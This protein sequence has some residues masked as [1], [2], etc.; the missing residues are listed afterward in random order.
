MNQKGHLFRKRKA[1]AI[2]RV[3]TQSQCDSIEV[4]TQYVQAYCKKHP[5]LELIKAH[6]L[7]ESAYCLKP[8]ELDEIIKNVPNGCAII[9]MKVDRLTRNTKDI[10]FFEEKIE[11]NDVEFHFIEE[12]IIWNKDSPR[13]ISNKMTALA[14][15]AEQES[16]STSDRTKKC[17]VVMRS[18]GKITYNAPFGYINYSE[19]KE[20]GWKPKAGEKEYV[21]DLFNMYSTGQY[22]IAG[23]TSI[24]NKKYKTKIDKPVTPQKAHNLL[25]NPFFIGKA[26]YNNGTYKHIYKTFIK[27]EVFETC[28]KLLKQKQPKNLAPRELISPL[29]HMVK[30]EKSG[31]SLTPYKKKNG[32]YMKTNKSVKDDLP[33]EKQ[34]IDGIY[35]A[36][37]PLNDNNE[38]KEILHTK[39]NAANIKT[40]EAV[41]N[42]IHSTQKEIKGYN[43]RAT[44]LLSGDLYG[45]SEE[46][47]KR[48]VFDLNL[49]I[50]NQKENLNTYKAQKLALLHD[51]VII[52][53]DL[54]E[55]FDNMSV[56]NKH[57]MLETLFSGITY[58]DGVLTYNFWPHIKNSS[59]SYRPAM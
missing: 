36:L 19:G 44:K 54:I 48:A 14:V 31:Y 3:S 6:Q 45:G 26:R 53:D 50:Q 35:N 40:I 42:K 51:Q 32:I 47:V 16:I 13:K 46:Q 28:Q 24:L 18:R 4:Q 8:Q 56:E 1:I 12:N 25:K 17:N 9:V 21:Q 22:S 27:K 2:Y 41:S 20:K 58:D 39:I 49:R 57:N 38:V 10:P 5:E 34:I 7:K 59:T 33:N 52:Y 30:H 55:T 29:Y 23:L 11:Q 43:E 15:T 37:K